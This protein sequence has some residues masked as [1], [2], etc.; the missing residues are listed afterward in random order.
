MH[1]ARGH[2]CASYPPPCSAP[3]QVIKKLTE[4]K[5]SAANPKLIKACAKLVSSNDEDEVGGTESQ[6]LPP[7]SRN[8]A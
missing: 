7:S 2:R 5:P 3:V 8:A 1:S 6:I 4:I